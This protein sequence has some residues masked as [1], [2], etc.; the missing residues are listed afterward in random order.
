ME[1]SEA[2]NIR[3]ELDLS[4]AEAMSITRFERGTGLISTNSNNLIVDFKASQLEKDLITTDRR[5]LQ[6]LK[7][8]LQKYGNQAYGRQVGGI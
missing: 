8:R 1:T 5:D 7:Q 3:E 2:G 6:E 4:E